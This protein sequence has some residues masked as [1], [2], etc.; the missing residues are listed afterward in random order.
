M[1]K[2]IESNSS[3]PS[4]NQAALKMYQD[5]RDLFHALAE[6][7]QSKTAKLNL[8]RGFALLI[9]LVVVV[10]W[11][12]GH[13]PL[14]L[15]GSI[16][17]G[18]LFL[19]LA[20]VHQ[21]CEHQL[22]TATCLFRIHREAAAA[23]ERDWSRLP[24]ID[25]PISDVFRPVALDLDL[26]GPRSLFQMLCV[27]HTPAGIETLSDWVS[28]P[29]MPPEIIDRQQAV[30]ALAPLAIF[31]ESFQLC[32]RKLAASQSGPT[33]F[34][35]WA[36]GPEWLDRRRWLVWLARLLAIAMIVLIFLLFNGLIDKQVGG[37]S[38]IGLIGVNFFLTVISTGSIHRIFNEVSS[39]HRD[40]YFYS[41]LFHMTASVPGQGT[42]LDSIRGLL[43]TS[44]R[45]A[46]V[47]VMKL[48]LI[49]G[50]ATMRRAGLFGLVYLLAQFGF[51]WDIHVLDLLERWQRRCRSDVR[52]WFLAVGRLEA[53][54]SLAKLS[55]DQPQ[56]TFPEVATPDAIEVISAKDL[57]HPLLSNEHR[58][59][60]DVEVGPAGTLLL[61]TGSNMSGKSTM[62]R[63]LGVNTVLAQAGSVVCSTNMRLPSIEIQ[64]S[65]RITDS[66][67]DGVSFFM[68]ELK[69]LKEIVDRARIIQSDQSRVLLYLLDEILQGTN[70]RERHI[71]VSKVAQ[72][73]LHCRAIGCISTHD[74]ELG[75]AEG[76]EGHCHTIHFREQ[77]HDGNSAS[78]MTFDYKLRPGVATTT[79]ALKLLELVGLSSDDTP[80]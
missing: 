38:I 50:M 18:L 34:I 30:K 47:E 44:D 16:V 74:L 23:V 5:R 3:Y 65:M 56:W 51:N 28:N 17:C 72:H 66:L 80:P 42:E 55:H 58:V 20:F 45:D 11:L 1:E 32:G 10:F 61:V 27:A 71:A 39:R 25:I 53:L 7:S 77:L 37:V 40:V 12:T 24:K 64:T 2:M 9:T 14:W 4:D 19:A 69:R 22:E 57:G 79:N 54:C 78:Q 13:G 31:R 60:N 52:D 43:K 26:F 21:R 35:D 67:A 76:L 46:C 8:A 62:L 15:A 33:A 68:A 63:A 70:S 49:M 48:G 29:A 59:C 73:L 36:E 6:S 75:M 41:Q